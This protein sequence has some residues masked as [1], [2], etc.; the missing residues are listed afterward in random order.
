[1]DIDPNDELL[2]AVYRA[3]LEDEAGVQVTNPNRMREFQFCAEVM[4]SLFGNSAS[5]EVIPHDD[6]PSVGT[7]RILSN[8]FRFKDPVKFARA[9]KLASNYEIYPRTDG[10]L[11]MALTFYGMT[12][13]QG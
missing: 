12:E 2:K 3:I 6:F 4:K 9:A 1:M 10:K 8:R 13:K 5:I 7:I 11:M